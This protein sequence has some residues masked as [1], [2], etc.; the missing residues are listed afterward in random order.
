[1]ATGKVKFY[2]RRKGYGFIVD[3]DTQKDIFFHHSGLAD[4]IN[5][6]DE[7]TFDIEI[8]DEGK[9]QKAVNIEKK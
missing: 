9:R 2:N 3:D 8:E 1:M 6:N 5:Q 4:I 7:V